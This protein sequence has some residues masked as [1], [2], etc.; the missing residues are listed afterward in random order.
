MFQTAAGV[1][2]PFPEKLRDEYQIYA[3]SIRL[4]PSFEKIQPLLMDFISQLEEPLFIVLEMPLNQNEEA[5]LRKQNNGPFHK[6]ICYLDGQSKAQVRDIMVQY[7]EILLNDG[8]SQFA[9]ASHVTGDDFFIQKYKLVDIY[10]KPANKYCALLKKHGFDETTNLLT[11]W[12]TFSREHPG[13]VERIQ[14]H[15]KDIYDVFQTLL[16]L[17]MYISKVAEE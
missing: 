1:T 7:G 14:Y 10:C 15:G 2:I 8:I 12:D 17:G 5:P 3:Y 16:K 6:K 9:V 13:S 11:P 4:T